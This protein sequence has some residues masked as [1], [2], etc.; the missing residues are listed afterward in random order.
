[1]LSSCGQGKSAL[2]TIQLCVDNDNGVAAFKQLLQSIAL[3]QGMRYID[4][5]GTT[6]RELRAVGATRENM[7]SNGGLL[8]VGV[9]GD[10]GLGLTAGN[11]G[12]NIYDVAVGFSAEPSVDAATRFA[13]HVV[14]RL[15]QSWTLNAVPEGTGALPDPKCVLTIRETP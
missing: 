1:M 8:F 13:D 7:H 6:M 11:L 2:F 3:E 4:S 10:G 5:S 12:L 9:E 15:K 14:A